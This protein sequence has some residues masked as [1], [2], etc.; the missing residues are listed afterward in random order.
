VHQVRPIRRLSPDGLIRRD[1]LIQITQKRP[2]YLDEAQQQ[3][4]NARYMTI[5]QQTPPSLKPDF[6]YRGGVTLIMDLDSFDVRFA[7]QKNVVSVD[8]LNRQ[9]KF[10]GATTGTS[11][12]ELYF[13][14]LDRGQRL[15]SL[16]VTDD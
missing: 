12:R 14:A 5:G 4:E 11:L 13:G 16:H 1:L 15:A 10:L 3:T 2:G 6:W 9:R 8:R 7:V